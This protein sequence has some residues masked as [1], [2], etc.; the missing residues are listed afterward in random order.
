MARYLS[1]LWFEEVNH[2]AA[3][4][5][6][7]REATAGADLTIQQIVTDGPEGDVRYWLRIDDGSVEAVPGDA[8]EADLEPHATVVQ[9][10]E[11]AA[12]VSRGELSTEDALLDGRIRLRGDIGVLARHQRILTRL[13]DVFAEVLGRTVYL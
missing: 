12:A 10:Y 4:S 8:Q 11:T 6:W 1:G 3:A 2:A 7:V 9:S 5:S 13:G